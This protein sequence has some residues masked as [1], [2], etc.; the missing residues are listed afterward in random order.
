MN[1]FR[2]SIP[3]DRPDDVVA[4]AESSGIRVDGKSFDSK[5]SPQIIPVLRAMANPRVRGGTLVKPVQSGGSTVGEILICFWAAFFH[6]QIQC[7]WPDQGAAEHRWKTRIVKL[8]LSV[9]DLIWAGGRYDETICQANFVNSMIIAQGVQAKGALDSDTIPFQ[10]NEEVHLW[11]KGLLEKARRRQTRVWDKKFLD[12]SNA[13]IEGDQLHRAYEAGSME[14]WENFCPGCGKWHVMRFRWDPKK[15]ELGGLRFDTDAGRLPNGKYNFN[16]IIPTIRY[17][18]PCGFIVRNNP[19][20]RRALIGRYRATNDGAIEE[21]RSWTYEAVSVIEIDWLDLV[22]EWLT[23]IRAKKSGD[24]EPLKKFVQ[25]R[26]CHF[27]NP[28]TSVPFHGQILVNNSLLKSREGMKY[29]I[30]RFWAFDRQ[31]GYKARGETPHFWLVIRDMDENANSLLVWEGMLQ[32]EADVLAK[33]KE[34]DCKLMSGC[35]DATWDRDNMLAFA[36]RSEFNAVTGSN[37]REYFSVKQADGS[38]VKRVWSKP[39]PLWRMMNMPAPKYNYHNDFNQLIKVVESVPDNREPRH[40]SYHKLGILKL[41]FFLR[42]HRQIAGENGIKW[43]VPGDVSEDYH[44]QLESWDVVVERQG[45]TNQVVEQFRQIALADHMLMCEAYI[46]MLMAMSGV[47]GR[48][49]AMLGIQD[50]TL[51]ADSQSNELK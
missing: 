29:K 49:L 51:G 48:R 20:E 36:H 34:Y 32:T 2:D 46:A 35:G 9:H 19:A 45:K 38:T 3:K 31:K 1:Y 4:W 42:S 12:I 10:V 30:A 14:V 33:L 41:L 44:H 15:P 22:R 17:Q 26:E 43:E 16:K 8:L 27:W 5:I 11:E 21:L 50:T 13:G 6:G 40:W 28:E 37:Q 24:I 18:M 7:N 47:L 39:E 23:A 25:E